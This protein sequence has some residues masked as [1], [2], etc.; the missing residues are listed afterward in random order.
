MREG[1]LGINT[2][3]GAVQVNQ[4]SS[5]LETRREAHRGHDLQRRAVEREHLQPAARVPAR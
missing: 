5:E 2:R 3:H 4:E 1:R